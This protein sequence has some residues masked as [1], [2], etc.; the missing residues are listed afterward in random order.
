MRG[1][2][3]PVEWTS[4]GSS[5]VPAAEGGEPG[6]P[7]T[8]SVGRLA[9]RGNGAAGALRGDACALAAAAAAGARS[10]GGFESAPAD[11]ARKRDALS[12][13]AQSRRAPASVTVAVAKA[14][15]VLP[16][17]LLLLLVLLQRSWGTWACHGSG[18]H[19]SARAAAQ[20]AAQARCCCCTWGARTGDQTSV[21]LAAV[22]AADCDAGAL[23][24]ASLSSAAEHVS[25]LSWPCESVGELLSEGGAGTAIVVAVAATV[26]EVE[27]AEVA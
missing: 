9:V 19:G 22:G 25:A 21:V 18:E 24:E 8:T 13:H 23:P 16:V 1:G 4:A 7:I 20:V 26:V 11:A 17:L 14:V 2:S 15:P 6:A 3:E 5:A 27:P 10:C 12:T